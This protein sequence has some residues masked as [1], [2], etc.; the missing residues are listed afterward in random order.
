MHEEKT[1]LTS[2]TRLAE[3]DVRIDVL[4]LYGSRAKGTARPDSDYD[5][6]VAFNHFPQNAWERR[7]QS[8]MLAL[9]WSDQLAL[10]EDH[11]SVADINLAPLPLALNIVQKGR[12]LV[13]KNTLRL[14][15]EENRVTSMWE[16]DYQY[17][18]KNYSRKKYG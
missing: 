10:P 17:S 2:C 15:R 3:Q 11:L 9:D 5:F 14:A 16:I 1:I 12:V 18:R 6:A 13:V 8:E 4:W 7:L